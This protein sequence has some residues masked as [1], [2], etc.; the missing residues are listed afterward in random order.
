MPGGNLDIV[1]NVAEASGA[2]DVA[3]SASRQGGDGVFQIGYLRLNGGN[4]RLGGGQGGLGGRYLELVAHL[5]FQLFVEQAEAFG[6]GFHG[7]LHDGELFVQLEELEIGVGHLAE[8]GEHQGTLAFFGSE[9][10]RA[11]RFRQTAGLA[12]DVQLPGDAAVNHAGRQRGA[13]GLHDVAAGVVG[14][15][16]EAAGV[17]RPREERGFRHGDVLACLFHARHGGLQVA[18][19]VVGVR[20]KVLKVLVLEHLPPG[21]VRDGLRGCSGAPECRGHGHVHGLEVGAHHA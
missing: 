7:L 19:V 16:A 1:G 6:V 3:G 15:L 20:Q 4:L 14:P 5:A 21:E 8:Q 18:V 13:R 12:P 11:R 2:A 10:I 17:V 9:V